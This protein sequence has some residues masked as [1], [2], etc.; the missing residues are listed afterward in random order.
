MKEDDDIA[1]IVNNTEVESFDIKPE[2]L[3]DMSAQ[4]DAYNSKMG[5]SKYWWF[6]L[7]LIPVIVLSIFLLSDSN[8]KKNIAEIRKN[9]PENELTDSS[10]S[11]DLFDKNNNRS[12]SDKSAA[13]NRLSDGID[14]NQT[15]SLQLHTTAI[16]NNT[17]NESTSLINSKSG[18]NTRIDLN[19]FQK[20]NFK[21]NGNSKVFNKTGSTQNIKSDLQ[22]DIFTTKKQQLQ[23]EARNNK[24]K[25]DASIELNISQSMDSTN[26]KNSQTFQNTADTVYTLMPEKVEFNENKTHQNILEEENYSVDSVKT[27]VQP[28]TSPNTTD[29][30]KN[31]PS[32]VNNSEPSSSENGDDEVDENNDKKA[33]LWSVGFTLGPDILRKQLTTNTE[34]LNFEQK[35]TEELFDNT[36]GYDFEVNRYLTPWLS[37]GSGIGFKKFQEVNSYSAKSTTTSDTTYTFEYNTY[38][39]F[40]D[41]MAVIGQDSLGPDTSWVYTDSIIVTESTTDT[42][43]TSNTQIDSS[44]KAANGIVTSTYVQIPINAQFIFVNTD[45]LTAYTNVGLTIGLLTKNTGRVIDYSSNE[46][47]N[48]T[49][50]KMIYNASIGLG[51]NYNIYGPF[52][53]KI[54]GAYQF[55]LTNFSLAPN[56]NKRY[57]GFNL[58]TGLVFHF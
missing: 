44:N 31:T 28:N 21:S 52:D 49:T 11:N 26:A 40:T 10:S 37:L 36:W 2:W 48:Y 5:V 41:S 45:K 12:Q 22:T 43:I 30:T 6:S 24:A 20:S 7:L 47:V 35:K 1:N 9:S 3:D 4:L 51:L 33:D 13:F 16:N 29:S 54:Y 57:N 56:V 8:E 18:L 46:L 50:R 23:T 53:Y 25:A 34:L 42:S 19:Q 55:S 17:V 32:I 14:D 39:V 27:N 15:D 58:R 38:P